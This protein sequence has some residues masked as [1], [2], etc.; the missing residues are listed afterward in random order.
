MPNYDYRCTN[1]GD[2]W[3]IRLPMA[4]REEPVELGR[5]AG[6]PS[7]GEKGTIEQFLPSAPGTPTHVGDSIS[8]RTPDAF[9]DVLRNIK[10]KHRHS[11][12]NV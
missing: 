9:K 5:D 11:T 1:C 12:I 8:K 10:S 7:C 2:A 3:E 6:C 4:R